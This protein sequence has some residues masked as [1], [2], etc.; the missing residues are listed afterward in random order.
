MSDEKDLK[1]WVALVTGASSG[2][3]KATSLALAREGAN[4]V[5]A[6]RREEKLEELADRIE[7]VHGV[8]CLSVP[9]NVRE[10]NQVENLVE[11]TVNEFGALDV[12]VNNAGTLQGTG[13]EDLSTEDYK[14]MTETNIDGVFYVTQATLPH[15]RESHGNLIFLGSFAGKFPRSYN[16]VYAAT[17][18]WVRGFAHSV[19]ALAGNDNVAVTVINPSEVRTEIGAGESTFKERFEEGSVTE[20]EEVAEAIVFAARQDN[21]TVS[22][23]DLFRRDKLTNF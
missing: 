18:W 19:E 12:V 20:P 16:P 23:L 15:L 22:E 4:T 7:E 9:T 8:K 1:G 3:G 6:A 14:A 21:S 13:L 10:K 5:V 11:R 2:I 17:K